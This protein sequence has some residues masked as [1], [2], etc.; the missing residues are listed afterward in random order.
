MPNRFAIA[1][2]VAFSVF[3]HADVTQPVCT[4]TG[5][6]T[7]AISFT[8]TGDSH[9]VTLSASSDP[10]GHTGRTTLLETKQ[11]EV[12]VSAGQPGERMYFF[13]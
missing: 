12:T 4:Q 13:P 11:S 2:F 6:N 3:A 8:L 10:T 1:F 5:P 7:Y 9:R